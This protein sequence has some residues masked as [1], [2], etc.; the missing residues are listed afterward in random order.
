MAFYPAYDIWI[1]IE[2]IA[3]RRE[4]VI[5]LSTGYDFDP[6]AAGRNSKDRVMGRRYADPIT[7][8]LDDENPL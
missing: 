4:A 3:N 2:K 7:F 1:D 8:A 6:L 5:Y